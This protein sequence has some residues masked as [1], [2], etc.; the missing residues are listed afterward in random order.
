MTGCF[1]G[2]YADLHLRP[3]HR[4]CLPCCTLTRLE[5]YLSYFKKLISLK[6]ISFQFP[7]LR[8]VGRSSICGMF[9]R[10]SLFDS[11]SS[12]CVA[13][14]ENKDGRDPF[15]R[16]FVSSCPEEGGASPSHRRH[17]P[18]KPWTQNSLQE[19][20]S[21]GSRAPMDQL[22]LGCA[23]SA[24]AASRWPCVKPGAGRRAV[25]C[26]GWLSPG[27]RKHF[28]RTFSAPVFRRDAHS[29]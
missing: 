24:R 9:I 14:D 10:F 3:Q 20:P 25:P 15:L 19:V 12:V 28:A 16:S 17:R 5:W 29:H 18:A 7:F 22:C 26:G 2:G 6:G 11:R 4:R 13:C 27:S 21:W 1:P 23:V 8:L